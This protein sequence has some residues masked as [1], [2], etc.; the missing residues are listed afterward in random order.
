MDNTSN[1]AAGFEA[2]HPRPLTALELA[3]LAIRCAETAERLRREYGYAEV[4]R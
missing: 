4:K 2:L 3:A 1:L